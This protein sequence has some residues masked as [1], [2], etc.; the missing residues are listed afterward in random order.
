MKTI[1]TLHI[2]FL[3]SAFSSAQ[4]NAIYW[5]VFKDKNNSPYSINK[6]SNFL[7]EKAISR[8]EHQHIKI[9]SSDLPIN[10]TYIDAVKTAGITVL[11]VSKWLNAIAATTTDSSKVEDIKSLPFVKE[12]KT[13]IVANKVDHKFDLEQSS[14]IGTTKN[15]TVKATS[16]LLN[17][18]ASLNQAQ[19]INVNCLH[20]LGY[21]GQGMTIAV[22]DAGFK[23]VNL[24]PAFDS[25]RMNGQLL[26]TR[27]FVSGGTSVYE[28]HPHGMNTLSCMVGNLSGQLVGTA[29]KADYWLLRTEDA[30]SESW[31]EEINWLSGAE[32]ADSVGAD[33]ISASLGYS[34]GMTNPAENHLFSQMD[35]NTTIVTKAA[36][37]AA[38]K[39][40]FVVT[41]AG[42][43][44][45][46]PW[47]KIVA[48]GDA[49]S[50]LT[51]GAV[52][53]LGMI[54][55]FSSR[56]L[57][58]DGR[59]KPNTVAQGMSAVVASEWG[60]VSRQNGTSLATPI[61]AGAV[62]CLWQANPTKTNME[63]LYAIQ[64]SA[65]RYSTPDSVVGYGIPDF[66]A[67]NAL[68]TGI[69][70]YP[71]SEDHWNVYPNP[72]NAECTISFFSSK[73]QLI[74]I[75]VLDV[76][77]RKIIDQ[78]KNVAEMNTTF[79]VQGIEKIPKGLYI[80]AIKIREKTC[81]KKI[82]KQ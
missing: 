36:D 56:G 29:P 27:D 28:D 35:G 46:P 45:G 68:L 17:Y 57:T 12:I 72:F 40:I 47:Y 44:G 80:V 74:E 3:F 54:A 21:Q 4:S 61:T 37:W 13:I 5:I 22:L 78:I 58:Y 73:K 9:N 10:P 18:G 8:R 32:F 42:N 23:N 2:F 6:P 50:V 82:I 65:N 63:I 76:S 14:V 41:A 51:V 75:E 64:Q 15:E 20:N 33:I 59:I 49:D 26:G 31:Q 43:E 81:F 7:S 39:G 70:N 52:D 62:A 30:A 71:L 67:T 53:S 77:G 69:N 66:C 60:G 25:L 16:N 79:N 34:T 19:Q 38:K 1:I 55:N 48:P 11:T 24:L